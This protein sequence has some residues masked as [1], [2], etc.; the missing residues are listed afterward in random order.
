MVVLLSANKG[1]QKEQ[2]ELEGGAVSCWSCWSAGFS[3]LVGKRDLVG[4]VPIH[5]P[6]GDV[7]EALGAVDMGG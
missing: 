7:V 5:V 4:S 6:K 3:R 2:E 1:L